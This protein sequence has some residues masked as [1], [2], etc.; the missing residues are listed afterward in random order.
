MP[1]QYQQQARV[2]P[3]LLAAKVVPQAPQAPKPPSRCS[4]SLPTPS[5][6]MVSQMS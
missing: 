2:A 3:M 4:R 1:A 5:L 6:R